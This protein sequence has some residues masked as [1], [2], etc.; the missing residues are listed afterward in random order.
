MKKKI[1]IRPPE[2]GDL[3]E[4]GVI[5][6]IIG[7]P[8]LISL[9]WCYVFSSE[10]ALTTI[11]TAF[12]WAVVFFGFLFKHFTYLAKGNHG[13]VIKNYLLS[14]DGGVNNGV[15]D[16]LHI[17]YDQRA[18]Y[19]F[20]FKLPFEGMIGEEIDM[21]TEV[22]CSDTISIPGKDTFQFSV[23]YKCPLTA[24]P[25]KFLP[26]YLLV[27]EKVAVDFFKSEIEAA[28]RRLFQ[29]NPIEAITLQWD[30]LKNTYLAG[31]FGGNNVVHPVE[32][33]YARFT[34]T[35]YLT[36]IKISEAGQKA[37]EAPSVAKELAGGIEALTAKGVDADV[38]AGVLTALQGHESPTQMMVYRG[39]ENALHVSL[40]GGKGQPQNKGRGKGKGKGKGG[41]K[42]AK[43]ETED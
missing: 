27:P 31:L 42:E 24:I 9:A 39:L 36:S 6:F 37:K 25:G 14:D 17:P 41:G 28:I 20:G 40:D 8:F 38:A 18:V 32:I 13:M 12:V 10:Y 15:V 22:D 4:V 23:T 35:P 3:I 30:T 16:P 29:E 21:I 43:A 1:K 2:I 7:A 33:Q 26:R 5:L 19:G 11:W 34:N